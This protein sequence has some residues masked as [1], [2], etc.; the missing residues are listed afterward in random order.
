MPLDVSSYTQCMYLVTIE[1]T[2]NHKKIRIKLLRNN[3]KNNI[4]H[5]YPY[6]VF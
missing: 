3:E 6:L 2:T 4:I 1:D 5:K